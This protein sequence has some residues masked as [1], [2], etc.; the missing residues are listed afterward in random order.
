MRLLL[1]SSCCCRVDEDTPHSTIF[2]FAQL[3]D[4]KQIL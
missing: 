1:D 3:S 4:V 2:L